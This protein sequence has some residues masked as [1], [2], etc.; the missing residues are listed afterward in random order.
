MKLK[1]IPI[2]VGASALAIAAPVRVGAEEP[3]Q[4]PTWTADLAQCLKLASEQ[5]APITSIRQQTNVQ[6]QNLLRLPT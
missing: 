3:S 4:P 2:L 1:L 5:P 6:V